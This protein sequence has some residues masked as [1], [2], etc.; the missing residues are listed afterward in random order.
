MAEEVDWGIGTQEEESKRDSDPDW[1]QFGM[2][3]NPDE[4]M[5]RIRSLPVIDETI[6]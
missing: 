2:A 1:E 5:K 3:E 6:G 4:L